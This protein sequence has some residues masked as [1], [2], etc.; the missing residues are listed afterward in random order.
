M[1]VYTETAFNMV[2]PALH[3]CGINAL[4]ET[5]HSYS[6]ISCFLNKSINE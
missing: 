1:V 5:R 3:I 2:D 4:Y 6:R